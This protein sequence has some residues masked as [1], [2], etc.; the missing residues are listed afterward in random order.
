MSPVFNSIMRIVVVTLLGG[1]G[2]ARADVGYK[3]VDTEYLFV[4]LAGSD[5]GEV[6]EKELENT[7]VNRFGKRNGTY[8]VLSHT[9]ALEY[10]PIEN[11]RLEVGAITG[12]HAISGV[13]D[14]DDLR[15]GSFQGLSLE[16]R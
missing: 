6:G 11:L 8:N 4:F 2:T 16:I 13:S 10:V 1:V 9:L 15:R 14:L 5:V 3:K 7:T 12:Y